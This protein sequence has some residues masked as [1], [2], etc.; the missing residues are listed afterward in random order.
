MP[1]GHQL[2][3]SRS[4]IFQW[5]THE[6][7]Q[8]R[9]ETEFRKAQGEPADDEYFSRVAERLVIKK[10]LRRALAVWGLTGDDMGVL[11]IHGTSTGTNVGSSLN[12]YS[13]YWVP[14][15]ACRWCPL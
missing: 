4:Q 5:L 11:S 6:H 12:P 1:Y 3:F 9:E 13:L 8:L 14:R 2:N 10:P 15:R 7:A